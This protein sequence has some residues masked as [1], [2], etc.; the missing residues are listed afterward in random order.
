MFNWRNLTA[1]EIG[2]W[3]LRGLLGGFLAGLA[4]IGMNMWFSTTVG[5]P[6]RGPLCTVASIAQGKAAI[7]HHTANAGYGFGIH[8]GLSLL[9]GLIFAI[10]TL[11]LLRWRNQEILSALG[12]GFGLLLFVVNFYGFARIFPAFQAPDKPFELA[13]HAFFGA[14]LSFAFYKPYL[15][16]ER[17]DTRPAATGVVLGRSASPGL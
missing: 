3:L 4:F 14:L 13:T 6:F 8:V 1:G 5:K 10:L 15:T 7:L 9:F 11:P 17:A 2:G 12:V 16:G